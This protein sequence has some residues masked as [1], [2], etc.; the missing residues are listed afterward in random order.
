[1]QKV[2]I[3]V[4]YE[5]ESEKR[6][7]GAFKGQGQCKNRLDFVFIARPTIQGCGVMVFVTPSRGICVRWVQ[8]SPS[9]VLFPFRV[10]TEQTTR[11]IR[12]KYS[13][14]GSYLFVL[15]RRATK[16]MTTKI[17]FKRFIFDTNRSII[18]NMIR[19][20]CLYRFS[21][22]NRILFTNYQN[23]GVN[24]DFR[25]QTSFNALSAQFLW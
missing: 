7:L 10:C 21:S 4:V 17:I 20:K 5:S 9:R 18:F 23:I 15:S 11:L 16:V 6:K 14:I 2:L 25:D 8:V 19:F 13:S 24:W 12:T 1:M 22:K 3:Q